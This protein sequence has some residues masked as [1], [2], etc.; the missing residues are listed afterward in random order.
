[1]AV[2]VRS[3]AA[4]VPGPRH[5]VDVTY[6]TPV[7][8][9]G[10]LWLKRDDL[11]SVSG[12]SGGKARTTW[13][14][15]EGARGLTTASSRHSPQQH[16]VA[17][18]ASVRGIPARCHIPQ[19]EETEATR[20]A[21]MAGIQIVSHPWPSYNAILCRAALLDAS[22]RGWTYIPFGME[23]YEAV[24]LTA[25]QVRNV[26]EEAARIVVTVGSG[27]TL[28]G[29]VEGLY[30]MGR[31]T[32]V[33]GVMVGALPLR[34][35]ALFAPFG[36]QADVK[37]VRSSIPYGSPATNCI[38]EG[39]EVDQNYEAKCIPYLLPGDLFWIVGMGLR[40]YHASRKS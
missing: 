1:M 19:G 7:E 29:I 8:R 26:P 4:Q 31:T 20:L 32:P 12:A 17:T 30:A 37:L 11:F 36:W 27:M 14:L 21:L 9:R 28:A 40:R 2:V 22:Q 16:I 39:V 25:A 6:C 15:S 10:S 18:V 24:R 3:V 33:L 5:T 35:L 34:R 23:S 38:I 13:V